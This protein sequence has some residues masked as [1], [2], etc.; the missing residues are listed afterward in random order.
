VL[1][2]LLRRKHVRFYDED[3]DLLED[4]IVEFKQAIEMSDIYSSI[5]SGTMDAFASIIS[6]NLNI[7]MWVLT[8]ITIVMA[9]PTMVFS[10]YGMNVKGL[11]LA[12]TPV[13]ATVISC[14]LALAA[15]I[16]LGKA[17]FT[18]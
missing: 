9:V 18:R 11:P 15:A 1:E 5:L 3:Q 13:F 2:K 4:V 17:K 14:A 7:V 6:N 12:G 10:F 8:V 16:W